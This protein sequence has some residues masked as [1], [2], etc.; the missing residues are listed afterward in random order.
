MSNVKKKHMLWRGP[1]RVLE[2]APIPVFTEEHTLGVD[3]M[4]YELGNAK[5]LSNVCV[6]Y[7]IQKQY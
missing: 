1:C 5:N 2:F 7:F 4:D 6:F 3:T